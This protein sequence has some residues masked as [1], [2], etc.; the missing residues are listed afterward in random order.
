M[1]EVLLTPTSFGLGFMVP[2]G[3]HFDG[4]GQHTFGHSGAGGS[5]AFGDIDNRLSFAYSLN[6]LTGGPHNERA[7]VLIDALYR[8]L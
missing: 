2:G 3:T 1:D 5:I 6:R 8:C 4:W 7:E